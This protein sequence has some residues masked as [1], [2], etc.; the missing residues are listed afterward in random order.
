MLLCYSF[1][2]YITH[3]SPNFPVGY[4]ASFFSTVVPPLCKWSPSPPFKWYISATRLRLCLYD[5]VISSSLSH[6]GHHRGKKK[7]IRTLC[8][9]QVLLK[10]KTVQV[11]IERPIAIPTDCVE[12][13][14]FFLNF[15][16]N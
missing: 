9:A 4:C 10:K 16:L 12:K 13:F 3:L 14:S 11:R 7:L 6:L 15:F 2:L 8:L 1:L 5:V